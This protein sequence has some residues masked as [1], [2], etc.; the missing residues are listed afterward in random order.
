M[1]TI[2]ILVET[3]GKDPTATIER[4]HRT[5]NQ[6]S[7]KRWPPSI[8]KSGIIIKPISFVGQQKK[9]G[10]IDQILIFRRTTL[11]PYMSPRPREPPD[12]ASSRDARH[13]IRTLATVLLPRCDIITRCST[14]P[15]KNAGIVHA[16][17]GPQEGHPTRCGHQHEMFN[18]TQF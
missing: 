18:I 11:T 7:H 9:K 15:K 6:H 5:A 12:A 14:S 3:Y 13:P 17:P 8:P 16:T 2:T 10:T 1:N 4:W